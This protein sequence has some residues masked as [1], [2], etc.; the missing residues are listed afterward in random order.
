V[1][2]HALLARLYRTALDHLG[3]VARPK[4]T[5]QRG[6]QIWIPIRSGYGFD[7]TR[8][9]VEK[10][11]R[12]IG[13]MGSGARHWKWHKN[14]RAGS[15]RLDYTQNAINPRSSRRTAC[16]RRARPGVGAAIEWTSSTT[17]PAP[18]RWTIRDVHDA[19]VGDPFPRLARRTCRLWRIRGPPDLS[20]FRAR[21]AGVVGDEH[22]WGP[23]LARRRDPT[24]S[25]SDDR[26]VA[27][28]ASEGPAEAAVEGRLAR[29]GSSEAR[30]RARC[31]RP[32][33]RSTHCS[34]SVPR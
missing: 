27:P 24:R 14:D 32:A 23:P 5:G 17:G 15:R 22:R 9:F 19:P 11:S 28:R 8:L 20:T 34:R 16:A 25:G 33:W 3:L 1:G 2:R 30:Q 7:D 13:Q 29:V 10:L 21:D 18:D 31:S 4:V 6:I 26:T 12:M